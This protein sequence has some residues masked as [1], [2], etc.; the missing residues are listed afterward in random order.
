MNDIMI[1]CA[2]GREIGERSSSGQFGGA[3]ETPHTE[4][5]AERTVPG[6]YGGTLRGTRCSGTGLR[7]ISAS[8]R[9]SE[10]YASVLYYQVEE[11]CVTPYPVPGGTMAESSKVCV[12]LCANPQNHKFLKSLY[13]A[14]LQGR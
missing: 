10:R 9:H 11:I 4:R 6:S 5:G 2:S 12:G 14:I 7:E 3:G 13:V 1:D 8:A